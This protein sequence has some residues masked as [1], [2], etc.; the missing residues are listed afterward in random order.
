M[1]F[2]LNSLALSES[3]E[4]QLRH[5]VTEE[6]LFADDAKTQP[7]VA[8]I[9]GTS[10][11][12]HRNAITALQNKLLKRGKG[13][14]STAESMREDG[15]DILVACTEGFSNLSYNDAPVDNDV[16]IRSLYSDPK[17]SWI[18]EQIEA[19]IEDTSAFLG[20]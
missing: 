10:S 7:I 1:S 18:K 9:Y 16:A 15:L 11:K 4:Y 12:Q 3:T 20:K 13:K 6:L 8:T 17:F 2:N 14:T 19:A 5:P